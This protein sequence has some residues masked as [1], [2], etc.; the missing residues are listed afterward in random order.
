M[1]FLHYFGWMPSALYN[2]YNIV[3]DALRNFY[4]LFGIPLFQVD[5]L[6]RFLRSIWAFQYKLY[7][8]QAICLPCWC[9]VQ[10]SRFLGL[11]SY[12][13]TVSEW[14]E[15]LDDLLDAL[16]LLIRFLMKDV[17]FFIAKHGSS[18]IF[19]VG[20]QEKLAKFSNWL[21]PEYLLRSEKPCI[22]F[23]KWK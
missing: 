4:I 9:N 2:S 3:S 1:I 15:G 8:I 7:I 19:T 18:S 22:S 13:P 16:L 23:W 6:F 17:L 5:W 20:S 10:S 12:H 11:Y 21:L 14:L